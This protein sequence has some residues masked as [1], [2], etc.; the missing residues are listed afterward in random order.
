MRKS[1]AV[2]AAAVLWVACGGTEEEQSAA[3]TQEQELR[4]GGG[5]CGPTTCAQGYFCCDANCGVCAPLGS[6]C[7]DVVRCAAPQ[8]QP[9]VQQ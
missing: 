7:L 4:F 6:S 9:E 2:L 1:L 8:P 3:A 5:A